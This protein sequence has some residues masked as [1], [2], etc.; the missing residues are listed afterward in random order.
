M[1]YD[2]ARQVNVK[3]WV[4][5]A[6]GT[7]FLGLRIFCK[8]QRGTR[9]W[10]DDWVLVQSW[11]ILV[12]CGAIAS[13][14]VAETTLHGGG[15][16][17]AAAS[18]AAAE[19]GHVSKLS[20][21][22][23]SL[24]FLGSA[25]SKTSFAITLTRISGPRVRYAL[26]GLVLSMNA[27]TV[28]S[29]VLRWAQCRPARKLWEHGAVEGTCWDEMVAFGFSM[30][31]AAYSTL[32]DFVLA[33]IPWPLILRLQMKTSEKIGVSVAMST[34]LAAGATAIV[35]CLKLHQIVGDS[36]PNRIFELTVWSAAEM[37]TTIMASSIPVLR[38]LVREAT[39]TNGRP[40]CPVQYVMRLSRQLPSKVRSRYGTSSTNNQF[41][42][43]L[44]SARRPTGGS[45]SYPRGGGDDAGSDTV[46]LDSSR[47]GVDGRIVK[48]ED[49]YIQYGHMDSHGDVASDLKSGTNGISYPWD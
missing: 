38:A 30:F 27:I 11:A 21:V 12:V 9:L 42:T 20:L 48:R 23:G 5:I 47:G 22:L 18:D 14:L 35:K 6:L 41:T 44:S 43:V 24:L 40:G 33:F 28:V 10:W 13:A 29:V 4:L 45:S 32:M 49:I 36:N 37:A 7:I 3:V 2:E 8:L 39:G 31:S 15:P 19:A 25:W 16:A 17:A 26:W 34:G 46:I 1:A